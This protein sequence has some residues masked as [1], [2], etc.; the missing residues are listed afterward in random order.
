MSICL[1]KN[2]VKPHK[3]STQSDN[4][5]KQRL[6]QLNELNLWGFT[7]LF[8]KKMLKNSAF[9]LEKQKCFIPKNANV[10]C[11]RPLGIFR[12]YG[13]K[14]SNYRRENLLEIKRQNIAG[15]CQQTLC[16]QK[17]FYLHLSYCKDWSQLHYLVDMNL[18]STFTVLN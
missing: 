18:F 8:F 1:E 15:S 2:F 14:N 12:D 13:L 4:R 17:L 3:L 6:N 11:E 10:V 7:K 5:Y 9:Y 16:F